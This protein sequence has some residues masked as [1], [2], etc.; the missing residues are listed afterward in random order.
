MGMG[1]RLRRRRDRLAANSS[2]PASRELLERLSLT[3]PECRAK[4]L[5]ARIAAMPRSFNILLR[6]PSHADL[7]PAQR[8]L[9]HEV[10]LDA[11]TR[12]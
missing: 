2:Q 5:I 11:G 1:V 4:T 9:E 12:H 6:G 8:E 10:S 3:H 7:L